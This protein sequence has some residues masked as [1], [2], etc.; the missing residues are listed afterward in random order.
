MIKYAAGY[1]G[2]L[3]VLLVVDLIW[4]GVIAKPLYS[5]GIGHLMAEQP[6][7][8]AA[9]AF[10]LIYPVGLIYFSVAPRNGVL[11]WSDT[12]LAAAVFG[13]IAYATYDLS[14]LATLKGWPTH[15]SII[16]IVWGTVLSTLA[17]AG[18]K[19]AFDWTAAQALR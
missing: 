12:L 9:A 15:L 17:A 3:L 19:A 10:Y 5:K 11:S 13:F 6:N 18:G 1:V 4:L 14:N 2:T 8:W 16:D 7:L